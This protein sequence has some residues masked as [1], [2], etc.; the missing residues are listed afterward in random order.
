MNINF[1]MQLS[2]RGEVRV[3]ASMSPPESDVSIDGWFPDGFAVFTAIDDEIVD[4]TGEEKSAVAMTCCE[5]AQ[6]RADR[7]YEVGA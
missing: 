3:E 6:Q 2:G 4:L 1:W 7:G 5:I